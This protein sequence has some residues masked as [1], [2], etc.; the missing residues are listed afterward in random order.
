[1][2]W[3]LLKILCYLSLGYFLVFKILKTYYVFWYY[4]RQ[5]AA[6]LS[7]PW[8]LLGNLM[9]IMKVFQTINIRSLRP[10]MVEYYHTVFGDKLPKVIMDFRNPDGTLIIN[11]P[12]MV[13]ELYVTK[14]K[15]FDKNIRSKTLMYFLFGDSIILERSNEMCMLKRKHLSAAFY[16]DKINQMME[17]VI[18]LTNSKV[19]KWLQK[20]DAKIN[21]TAEIQD[22][23]T[24]CIQGCIFGQ[25]NL[26]RKI[27]FI[28]SPNPV[29]QMNPGRFV[30]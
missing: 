3:E 1:M 12:S 14:N 17:T 11:D 20:E 18:T 16:K 6:A 7:V 15:Y 21:I 9:L 13:N 28:D 10:A 8:P 30:R 27:D 19:K 25:S 23:I 2:I 26:N 5:G 22:L 24:E 4:K 29:S